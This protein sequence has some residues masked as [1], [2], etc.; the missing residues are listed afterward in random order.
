[1]DTNGTADQKAIKDKYSAYAFTVFLNLTGL[2]SI[3]T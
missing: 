2:P 3:A 1:M